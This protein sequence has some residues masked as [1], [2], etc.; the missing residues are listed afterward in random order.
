MSNKVIG[1]DQEKTI[2]DNV[3]GLSDAR[4]LNRQNDTRLQYGTK[5]TQTASTEAGNFACPQH[6]PLS[7]SERYFSCQFRILWAKFDST[8]HSNLPMRRWPF[9]FAVVCFSG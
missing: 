7:T 1:Q 3:I 9:L 8:R 5:S 2:K 4:K 6:A